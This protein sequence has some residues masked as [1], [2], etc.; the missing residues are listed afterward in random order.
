MAGELRSGLLKWLF[1]LPCENRLLKSV[2]TMATGLN[3]FLKHIKSN[4]QNDTLLDRFMALL[5]ELEAKARKPYLEKLFILLESSNPHGT[6]RAAYFNLQVA[7]SEAPGTVLEL[8]ALHWVERAFILLG[9]SQHASLVKEE[10][11]RLKKTPAPAA[12]DLRKKTSPTDQSIRSSKVEDKRNKVEDRRTKAELLKPAKP[13][14]IKAADE[15]FTTQRADF[16][17]SLYESF[18]KQLLDALTVQLMKFQG[19]MHADAAASHVIQSFRQVYAEMSSTLR[20]ALAVFGHNP[21]LYDEKDQF[22]EALLQAFLGSPLFFKNK[23]QIAPQRIRLV[24]T[25]LTAWFDQQQS[26]PPSSLSLEQDRLQNKLLQIAVGA[27]LLV[28]D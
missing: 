17:S 15:R 7:R 19:P 13:E 9:K 28:E 10:I 5:V 23:D 1:S 11:E 6:L 4:P 12:V 14:E 16:I 2:K 8:E 27:V 20:N 24:A 3:D 22:R 26:M 18:A 21:L 25:L